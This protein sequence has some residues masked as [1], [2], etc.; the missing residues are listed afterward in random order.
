MHFPALPDHA[1]AIALLHAGYDFHQRGFTRAVFAEQQMDFAGVNG[2]VAIAEGSDAAKSFLDAFEF[3]EHCYCHSTLSG[4]CMD[5]GLVTAPT[6]T[7]IPT[8]C[9]QKV[10]VLA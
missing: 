10:M 9:S 5:C 1:A 6:C 2:E 8:K 4:D 3:E 7:G